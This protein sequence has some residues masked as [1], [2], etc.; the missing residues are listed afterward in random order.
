MRSKPPRLGSQLLRSSRDPG[1]FDQVHVVFGGTG[2]VGGATALQLIS[3]FEE[4]ARSRPE[5]LAAA[6]PRIVVTGHTKQEIRR[7]TRVLFQ[8]QARDHGA[9]PERFKSIGYRTV[10]GV[11]VELTLL[12]VD[13]SLPG[14]ER[15][16][17][18]DAAGR[19]TAVREFLAA[20]GLAP[21]APAT[22]KYE[23]LEDCLRRRVGQPFSRF[24]LDYRERRGLPAGTTRY[25]S[26]VVAIPL[27]SLAAY[28][29]TN[30]EEAIG[31]MGLGS[32]TERLEHLK[33][34]YLQA[35]RD[36]LSYAAEH[37][38]DEV[39]AAHTTAVGGMYDEEEDGSRT[40]RLGFAH[41]ALD[42]KLR[43]KQ[44]FAERLAA[45]YASSR[46]KMLITAAAIGVDAVLV[47][48]SP[49]LNAGIRRQLQRAAADGHPVLPAADLGA[50]AHI[51]PP[52]DIDLLAEKHEAVRFEHGRPLVLDYI[53]KSG[54]NGYFTVSNTDALYRVMRVTS[55]SELGL[56]LARTALFGD[57]PHRPAFPGNICHYTETDNSRQVFDLLG[58]PQLRRNQLSGLQP[59]ALQ[60]L[61]SA[62]HQAELHT[63]GLLI[64]LHRLKTLDLSAIPPHVN[65]ATFNPQEYFESHS[66]ASTL[67]QAARWEPEALADELAKFVTARSP[68]D[69]ESFQH[70]FQSDP[71]RQEAAHR[72][73]EEVLH[74]LWAV[75]S[76]GTPIV[77]ERAG[78]RRGVFGYYAT[79]ADR[80]MTHR[81]SFAQHL[82]ERFGSAIGG[83][84]D[85]FEHLVE[86]HIANNGCADLRPVAVL[87]SAR[88]SE[89][90][91]AGKVQVFDNE[92][93]FLSALHALPPYSYFTSSGLIALRARLKGL[94][95]AA[96][97]FDPSLGT[98]NE[99]RA[100]LP[101]DERGRPLLVPGVIES[102]RM[103]SEGL[104]KNTGSERL[105]GQ[106]GYYL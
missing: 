64:L 102:F 66:E 26:V 97:Q 45:L 56:L 31:L 82:R 87:V 34:L 67:E 96:Q 29:L 21:A 25:R 16:E 84:E 69:L 41:S 14:L 18:R 33:D 3:L 65:L 17:Q 53:L 61:G 42:R 94:L 11:L 57:D 13:P 95:R 36:D 106:W 40:I 79:A 76:L 28:K 77:Y 39:L 19:D 78:R 73:L 50:R 44:V 24:L 12:A 60:D 49:P 47:R 58:Q 7:F 55:S 22:A 85:A 59:K 30:L 88:S 48:E 52:L 83:D 93:D 98:A 2:A 72:V 75:P 101:R 71:S 99:F 5:E 4:A 10:G 68:E 74:A 54:E 80:V 27:A 103:V 20:G 62:K 46:I 63:L 35:I 6:T 38:A 92:D 9:Q 70:L 100:H 15:F 91:L 90:D 23:Y 81:D 89:G 8:I 32:D 104:E 51:Y 43:D 37:L 105:D 86:F 1:F